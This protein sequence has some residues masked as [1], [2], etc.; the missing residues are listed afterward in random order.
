MMVWDAVVA[1]FGGW[2]GESLGAGPSSPPLAHE[3]GLH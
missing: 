3:P 2:S 1:G